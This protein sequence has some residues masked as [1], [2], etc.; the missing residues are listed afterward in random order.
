[1]TQDGDNLSTGLA[2][3]LGAPD[4]YGEA[5]LVLVET[6]IHALIAK[7]SLS[8]L[9]AVDIIDDAVQVQSAIDED[10][11]HVPGARPRAAAL[12]RIIG[13]SLSSDLPMS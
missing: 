10:Q 11:C 3:S 4:P 8:T 13:G 9:E 6:L 1:M 5:A 7:G 12:L 2:A